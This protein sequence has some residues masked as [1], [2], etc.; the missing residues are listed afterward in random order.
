M[1]VQWLTSPF[2]ELVDLAR[3]VVA[4]RQAVRAPGDHARAFDAGGFVAAARVEERLT[5]ARRARP[6]RIDLEALALG[7]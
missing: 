1:V 2:G 7:G 3:R 6:A 5:D 4:Q